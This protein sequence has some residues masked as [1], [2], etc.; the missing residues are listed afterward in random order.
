MLLVLYI[1]MSLVI[2]DDI[3]IDQK[4]SQV[5]QRVVI[6]YEPKTHEYYKKLRKEKLDPILLTESDN[7]F[8]FHFKW[9]PYT[10]ARNGID[11]N[12]PLCFD[13]DNLIRY[14]HMNRLNNLWINP[15][16]DAGGYYQGY[17]GDALGQGPNFNI[18]GRGEHPEWNLFRLPIMDCYLAKD[19]N[20]QFITMGP[21]LTELEIKEIYR[22]SE[23]DKK[24]YKKN[25]GERK[26]NLQNM[27]QYYSYSVK[28]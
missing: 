1:N 4:K 24:A 16:D 12:G 19:H 8:K 3:E 26:P 23:L 22:L 18:R 17:Y 28:N 14:F 11:E 20:E 25:F 21:L 13:P 15:T 10:G 27:Y 6:E 2:D 9:N 7:P 5:K